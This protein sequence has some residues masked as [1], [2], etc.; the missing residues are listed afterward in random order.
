MVKTQG[1]SDYDRLD[2]LVAELCDKHGLRLAVSGWTRKTYDVLAGDRQRMPRST[3]LA[4]IESFATTSGEI[5]V[6]D[7]RA[8]AFAEELGAALEQAF[9]IAEAVV[10][11]VPRPE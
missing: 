9:G 3:L 10:L 5:R 6:F 7:D 1:P 4:R 11:R 2:T 8:I